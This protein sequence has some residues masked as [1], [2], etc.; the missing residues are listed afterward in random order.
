MSAGHVKIDED[1]TVE[2]FEGGDMQKKMDA[3]PGTDLEKAMT[4]MLLHVGAIYNNGE[5]SER[6]TEVL[7]INL[8]NLCGIL[9]LDQDRLQNLA[10]MIGPLVGLEL[11]D[12]APKDH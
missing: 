7:N 1:G 2:I 8:M 12:H 9:K 6:A 3:I 10:K 5:M 4:Q 11:H